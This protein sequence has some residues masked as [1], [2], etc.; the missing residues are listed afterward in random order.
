MDGI[1]EIQN[2]RFFAT[3]E[4]LNVLKARFEHVQIWW[5]DW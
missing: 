4:K 2:S 5:K 1:Q 3:L